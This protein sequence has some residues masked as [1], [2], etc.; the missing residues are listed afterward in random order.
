MPRGLMPEHIGPLVDRLRAGDH[1]AVSLPDVAALT[2]VLMRSLE[3]YFKSIDLTI[4]QECQSLADYIDDARSEI[5]SLSPD[6]SDEAGIPR[7]GLELAAIV[8]Q[9][10]SATNTIMES[11]EQIMDADPADPEA[12][13]TTINDAVMQIFEACSFQDIT[14]QRIS[15]VVSTLEHVEERVGRLIGILGVMEGG[16]NKEKADEDIDENKA[17]LNG[18]ALDGEGIDQ[19]EIDDLLNGISPDEDNVDTQE[20]AQEVEEVSANEQEPAAE[21]SEEAATDDI[22]FMFAGGSDAPQTE[23]ENNNTVTEE[24]AKEVVKEVVKEV[25]KEVPEPHPNLI[26]QAKQRKAQ[27]QAE[28]KAKAEPAKPVVYEQDAKAGLDPKVTENTTQSDIDALF[29]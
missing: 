20:V 3:S 2:E 29:S 26:E 9:T 28:K 24:A 13:K 7:A 16:Q 11:A 17:L 12:Y 15:K 27:A 19:T 23:S 6:H 1:Q 22:D 8:Q 14:G 21:I 10:E 4:Y 25:T 18:P 5:S